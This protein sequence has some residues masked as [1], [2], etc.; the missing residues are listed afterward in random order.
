MKEEIKLED[1]LNDVA[2]SFDIDINDFKPEKGVS[3]VCPTCKAYYSEKDK[4]CSK[5]GAELQKN[6]YEFLSDDTK[7]FIIGIFHDFDTADVPEDFP[8]EYID[9]LEKRGD[10]SGY[11]MN[12]IFKRNSDDKFFYYTSYDGRLEED[13][14]RETS[15]VVKTTWDFEKHFS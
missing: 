9:S 11:Y 15:K 1:F 10:G 14:L 2:K 6:E 5:D 12:F 7:D 13:T 8:Y 4:F 3:Y